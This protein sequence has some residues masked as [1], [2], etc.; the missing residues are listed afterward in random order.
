MYYIGH[1][2]NVLYCYFDL[3]PE[4]SCIKSTP[5]SRLKNADQSATIHCLAPVI[6][7]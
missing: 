7:C 3:H 4:N 2:Y 6:F 5:T 1:T